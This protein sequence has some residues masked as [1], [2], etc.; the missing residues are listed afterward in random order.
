MC[1]ATRVE[2]TNKIFNKKK[3]L[4]LFPPSI[5]SMSLWLTKIQGR[6]EVSLYRIYIYCRKVNNSAPGRA[7]VIIKRAETHPCIIMTSNIDCI[8]RYACVCLLPLKNI[9]LTRPLP[10]PPSIRHES[11][12]IIKKT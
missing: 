2:C 8:V 12:L 4:Y 5:P 1:D 11:D 9:I 10:P 6:N 7:I 3:Q